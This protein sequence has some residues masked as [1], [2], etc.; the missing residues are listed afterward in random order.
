VTMAKHCGFVA[1]G[2][3]LADFVRGD[4]Y[5]R[6]SIAAN[7]VDPGYPLR[8]ADHWPGLFDRDIDACSPTRARW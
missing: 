1:P 4:L 5:W 3:A 8:I 2:G 7:A 6:F